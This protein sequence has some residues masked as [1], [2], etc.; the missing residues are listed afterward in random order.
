[1]KKPGSGTERKRD[2]MNN[3]ESSVMVATENVNSIRD[4]I[5]TIRGVQMIL[6]R[7]LA[8]VSGLNIGRA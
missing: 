3:H 1:M 6:G 2:G 5:F 8:A 7:D 4:C